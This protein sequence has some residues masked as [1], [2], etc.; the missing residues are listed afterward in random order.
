MAFQVNF[1]TRGTMNHLPNDPASEKS[2]LG[3]VLI[4]PD[5]FKTL[6]LSK[7]DFYQIQN[8]SIYEAFTNISERDEPIDYIVV[9]Q[10]LR[11]LNS[12]VTSSELAQLMSETPS[13]MNYQAYAKI[14]KNMSAKRSMLNIFTAG[15]SACLN[16]KEPNEIRTS[17]EMELNKVSSINKA[18]DHVYT[19]KEAS[20]NALNATETAST[21]V[22][23]F[24][25]GIDA[26]DDALWLSNGD[27]SIIG[28]RPGT[29]KTVL[30][31]TAIAN[32]PY[33]R[34]LLFELESGNEQVTQRILAQLSG[35]PAWRI[36][37]GKLR[38]DETQKYYDAIANFETWN[39]V[40]CDLPAM[41]LSQIRN[42]ARKEH[43]KKPLDYIMVDYLQLANGDG[44]HE[45]RAREIGQVAQGLKELAKE[46]HIPVIAAA[47]INRE[48]QAT[49]DKRPQLHNLKESG[50][51]EQA[52]DSVVFVHITDTGSRQLIIAKQR[53]GRLCEMDI[54]FEE[55]VMK[56][57]DAKTETVRLNYQDKD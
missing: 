50:D 40:I 57:S 45:S 30:I 32:N 17:V 55:E 39:T 13:S 52:A 48:S 5:I 37:R 36:V 54:Y 31:V 9:C 47:Q 10:E 6:D 4:D 35:I 27:F 14:V 1:E 46:L 29:G 33:K 49:S 2:I 25:F 20:L 7:D 34:G 22:R 16:G 44:K 28:G 18:D 56:F 51:L 19:A 21:G 41:R 8:K 12:D 23:V 42:V 26:L 15:A 53:I 11:K 38:D 24:N 43:L 3:S